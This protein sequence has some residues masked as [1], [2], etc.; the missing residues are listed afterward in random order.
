MME[1]IFIFILG[2][3]IGSFLNV[4]IYR[5]PQDLSIV[6]PSSR[7]PSCGTPIKFYDNIPVISYMLLRGRCRSCKAP[8]S[9]RYPLVELL[10]AVLYVTVLSRFIGASSGVLLV[11]FVFVSALVVIIFIDLDHQ[12]IPN[13]ITLPG[14]PLAVV[15]SSTI[16]PDPFSHFELLGIKSSVIGVLAGGG[17]FYLIAVTGKAIL[18]KD[19]M[20]MGDIKMM[21]LVGGVLGWKGVVLTT[22]IGS[23]LGSVIGVSLIFLKGREWGSRIP[24][25]PYLAAGALVSLFW[26]QDIL[27][28]YLG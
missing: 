18:K 16:L 13:S 25:G 4:C 10:N 11:Y 19:A 17:S 6:T 27:M 28:W 23:L 1:Y 12:I 3:L 9:L 8:L 24:F 14:I 15:L 7:C 26:G 5:M 2:A 21:A 22:F 20:G